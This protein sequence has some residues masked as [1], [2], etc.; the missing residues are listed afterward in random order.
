MFV[1]VTTCCMPGIS[2]ELSSELMRGNAMCD[3]KMPCGGC[4]L[5]FYVMVLWI[6]AFLQQSFAPRTYCCSSSCSWSNFYLRLM[7]FR[8]VWSLSMKKHRDGVFLTEFYGQMRS[9]QRWR[10]N[11]A[12]H[13]QHRMSRLLW[14]I[15]SISLGMLIDMQS[16]RIASI[17]RRIL[18]GAAIELYSHFFVTRGSK[19]TN[20]LVNVIIFETCTW[21]LTI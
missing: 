12:D 10:M 15:L 6:I 5:I 11:P 17:N 2:Y 18:K 14:P 9:L 13:F 7:I 19:H 21:L 20:Q 8:F 3:A 16:F 4:W 1:I